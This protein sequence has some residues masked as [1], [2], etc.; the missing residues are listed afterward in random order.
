MGTKENGQIINVFWPYSQCIF[1]NAA[2]N[3]MPK[4]IGHYFPT[5]D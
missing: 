5:E 3:L 4:E 1:Y 2:H